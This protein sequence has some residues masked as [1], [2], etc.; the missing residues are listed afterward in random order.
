MIGSAVSAPCRP[1]TY[2][3]LIIFMIVGIGEELMNF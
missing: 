1:E 2:S 3:A